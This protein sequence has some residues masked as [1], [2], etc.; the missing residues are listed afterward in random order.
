MKRIGMCLGALVWL[1]ASAAQAQEPA[2]S[3]FDK[4]PEQAPYQSQPGT[5]AE[6]SSSHISWGQLQPTAEMW[7]YEQNKADYLDPKLAVRRNAE[8]KTSERQSRIAAMKWYG[9]SNS[10]PIANP[11]PMCGVY[12][13]GWHANN[14]NAYRWTW[15]GGY[16]LL[17]VRSPR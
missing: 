5:A 12:S 13:P 3:P 7:L 14:Y 8:R 1:A 16:P 11:T 6:P 2:P 17:L 4:P 15:N 9:L 10:R